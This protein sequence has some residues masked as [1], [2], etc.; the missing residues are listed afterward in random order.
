MLEHLEKFRN[1]Y[2]YFEKSET[3]GKQLK[4]LGTYP[5]VLEK[6]ETMGNH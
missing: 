3:V 6:T 5:K 2:T 4:R 1:V